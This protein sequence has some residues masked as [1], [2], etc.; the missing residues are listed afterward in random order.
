MLIVHQIQ[1][2]K[3]ASHILAMVVRV[4]MRLMLV[5]PLKMVQSC[6]PM[7]LPKVGPLP[8]E[9]PVAFDVKPGSCPNPINLKDQGVLPVAIVGTADFDVTQIDPATV[10]LYLNDPLLGVSPIRWVFADVTTPYSPY[11]GKPLV[12]LACN[13]LGADGYLDLTFKYNNKEVVTMLGQVS[14]GQG[15]T[16]KMTGN[17]KA[18]FGGTTIVGEDI[19][20]IVNK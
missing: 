11:I 5:S 14:I 16:L 20:V 4:L 15:L 17:L 12:K 2:V 7:W 6:A 1:M 8:P 18:E 3:L 9:I 10:K 19:V 13:K